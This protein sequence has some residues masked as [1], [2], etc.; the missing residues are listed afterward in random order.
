MEE[1]RIISISFE[2]LYDD[3]LVFTVYRPNGKRKY[4]KFNRTSARR[5][6]QTLQKMENLKI[7]LY[8]SSIYFDRI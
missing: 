5:Y 3:K 6:L 2:R 4:T 7:D 1:N 8:V